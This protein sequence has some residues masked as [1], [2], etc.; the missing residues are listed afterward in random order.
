VNI[1]RLQMP[2]ALL[3]PRLLSPRAALENVHHVLRAAGLRGRA[4]CGPRAR[5]SCGR[6]RRCCAWW[7]R[8]PWPHCAGLPAV[9]RPWRVRGGSRRRRGRWCGGWLVRRWRRGWRG[10]AGRWARG[11]FGWGGRG[12][13][14]GGRV[15]GGSGGCW[16]GWWAG[17]GRGD[18][19][20]RGGGGGGGGAGGGGGGGGRGPRG[21]GDGCGRLKAVL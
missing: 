20:G 13:G 4:A 9:L 6:W 2:P 16:A 1:L 17:R 14:S 7:M 12:R 10:V 11:W 5:W 18:G 21:R 15:R 3:D 19:C 8:A